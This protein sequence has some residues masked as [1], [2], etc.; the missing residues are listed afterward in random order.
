MPTLRRAGVKVAFW[1]PDAVSSFGRQKMLLAP[2]DAMFFKEP[3]VVER[4]RAT[5]D[6]PVHYLPQGCNPR[7]H[8]PMTARRHGAPSGYR[9]QYVSEPGPVA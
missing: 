2:Y 3:H 5:L 9:R 6:L 4:L 7:W 8:R 1:F